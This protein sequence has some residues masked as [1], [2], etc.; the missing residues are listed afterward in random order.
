VG[1]RRRR[2]PPQGGSTGAAKIAWRGPES[3]HSK[4]SSY[5]YTAPV[6]WE[7]PGPAEITGPL[8]TEEE[9]LGST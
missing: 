3:I 4:M 2:G 9:E 1:D 5:S 8:W 6:E 7:S